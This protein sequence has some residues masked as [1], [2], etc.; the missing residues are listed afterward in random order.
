MKI[1]TSP[2]KYDGFIAQYQLDKIL[3]S[4]TLN[5][6]RL[7][8]IQAS[9]YL[10]LQN[11]KA[12]YLYFL[13]DGRLQIERYE[14]N[15]NKVIFSFENTFSVIGDLELFNDPDKE[16]LIHSTI[17]ALSDC[18]L[19]ALPL[20]S[21]QQNELNSPIFLQFICQQLSKKLYHASQLHSNSSYDVEYKLRRY[22]AFTYNQYGSDFKLENRESIAAMLG[23]SVRQLNRTLSKLAQEN[24]IRYK[25][26]HVIIINADDLLNYD[27]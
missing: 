3:H 5:S 19:L 7:V 18:Y 1:I 12:S 6:A 14:L 15:G 11:S 21:I 20:S 22:L 2:Q 27:Q 13:V 9:E 23:V 26:K 10:T 25:G 17:Q 24:L 8:K 16:N 4:E